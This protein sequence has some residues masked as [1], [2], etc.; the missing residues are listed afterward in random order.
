MLS[1]LLEKALRGFFHHFYTSR[2]DVANLIQSLLPGERFGSARSLVSFLV[3]IGV[4]DAKPGGRYRL[5]EEV[6]RGQVRVAERFG[7]VDGDGNWVVSRLTYA[8]PVI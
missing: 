2:T 4:V 1:G 3:S 8:A 5:G 7:S 6:V